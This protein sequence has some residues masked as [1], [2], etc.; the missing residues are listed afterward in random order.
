MALRF[1]LQQACEGRHF[2]ESLASLFSLQH[3]DLARYNY[4]IPTTVTGN[5]VSGLGWS[6]PCNSTTLPG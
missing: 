6:V 2:M 4:T 5:R 3:M 1:P